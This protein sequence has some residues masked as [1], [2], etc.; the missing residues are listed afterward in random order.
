MARYIDAE[1]P[2]REFEDLMQE[3]NTLCCPMIK[4]SDV[5]R[6]IKNAPTADVVEVNHGEWI[7][8][9]DGSGTCKI[10]NTHQKAIWDMDNWQNFCG[11]C[12]AKMDR[13]KTTQ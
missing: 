10:C 3:Y 5:L 11:H 13:E 1:K 4:I 6:T 7:L 2:I 12:G 9:P 8:H